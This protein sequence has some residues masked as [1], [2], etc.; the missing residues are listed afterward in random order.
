MRQHI[1][2]EENIDDKQLSQIIQSDGIYHWNK[3]WPVWRV[4]KQ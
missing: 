1:V 4:N 3:I 2:F